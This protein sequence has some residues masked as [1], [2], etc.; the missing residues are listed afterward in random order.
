MR[1]MYAGQERTLLWRSAPGTAMHDTPLL[2][3]RL[4]GTPL[5]ERDGVAL[6]LPHLKAQALLYYLAASRASYSRDHL[7][8]LLWGDAVLNNARHSLRSA[9]YRLRQAL[10]ALGAGDA[11]LVEGD[12]LALDWRRVECDLVRFQ[13]LLASGAES[14][15]RAAVGLIRGSFLQGFSLPDAILFD[16][17]V[18]QQDAWLTRHHQRALEQL[19]AFAEQRGDWEQAMGDLQALVRLDPL[20]ERPHQRLMALYVR[21]GSPGLAQRH[22]QFVERTLHQ[23]LGIAPA[24]E[25]RA[26][27]RS[28]LVHQRTS[29]VAGAAR[30]P[31]VRARPYMLSF[32]GR[33]SSLA[34]LQQI[35]VQVAG[36]IGRAVLIEGDAGIGKSRLVDE[37]AATLS[38]AAPGDRSWQ[39]LQGR[40]SPFDTILA[41][42]AFREAFDQLLPADVDEP[43]GAEPSAGASSD[44]FARLILRTLTTLSQQG[45]ILLAIDDLHVADQLSLNLFGYLAL[46]L[47][48][49]PI[50][51][52]GTVQRLDETAALRELATLGRRRGDIEHLRLASL[53]VDAVRR[54]LSDLKVSEAA[55]ALLAPWLA[56]RSAGNPF[57]IEALIDQLRAEHLLI[58]QQGSWQ[59]DNARWMAWRAATLLPEST[60]DLVRLRLSALGPLARRVVELLAVAGGRLPVELIPV[61]MEREAP[62]TGEAIEELLERRLAVEQGET[63]ALAHELLRE[64]ALHQLSSRSRQAV[65]RRLAAAWE[66]HVPATPQT[67]EQIARHA[68]ACGDLE[69]AYRYGLALLSDLP[70]AYTGAE[71]VAF[72]QRLADLVSP[73]APLEDQYRLAQA[74]GQAHRSLGQIE[75][76]RDWHQRQLHLAQQAGSVEAEAI[77]YFELAE[78]SFI[79]N[80]YGAAIAA[81]QQ[82]LGCA[83]QAPDL[84]QPALLSRGHRLLGGALAMEGSDL[85]AAEQHL[86]AAIPVHR[87]AGDSIN[88]SAALFELGNVVAQQGAIHQAIAMYREAGAVLHADQAPFLHALAANNLAYH[89]LVLGQVDD[90]RRELQRGQT[91]AG[92]HGL[93]TALLHLFSTES[94]IHLYTGNWDGAEATSCHGLALA[95]TLGNIERQAGYRASLALVAARRGRIA[96]ARDQLEAALGMIASRTFWHL[97]T[98]LLLWLAELT[99]EHDPAAANPYLDTA[100][101]LARTQRRRLLQ[102]HAERLQALALARHDIAAAQAALLELLD[103]ASTLDLSLE[104]A[105]TRAALARV[106]LQ[107]APRSASGRAFFETALR[108][109]TG[110]GA[111]AEA[112]ALRATVS[113][114]TSSVS[115]R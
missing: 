43:D 91:I 1:A 29:T 9:L 113:S 73:A 102:L 56:G 104:I 84:Q 103:Q 105:R 93:S 27:L 36:G 24:E 5:A 41:Y 23:E 112:A 3:I 100:L 86:R 114:I 2:T 64:V 57:V 18:H 99:L 66:R 26:I 49:M 72:L 47:Q 8:A 83:A 96:D 78:M 115:H 81:A 69:R 79:R 107:H 22:F 20:D 62:A 77:A 108:E 51:L 32:A 59:L 101:A 52:I 50:M 87:Q 106:T 80:D 65:H 89:H 16:E 111:Y 71:T 7:A 74:L 90:A 85:Q 45:P 68:V 12:R 55:G 76:A 94:E 4:L 13:Q 75:Q 34:R 31:F 25:T 60:H 82:G 42:G 40:C 6:T 44:R 30:V 70:H 35:S 11:L 109:L 67:A 46:R 48:R 95:E 58:L 97:R 10:D 88:L 38:S 61:A 14:D 15:L 28:A 33:E 53:D 17:F 19:S 37:F 21:S 92:R 54:I 39:I 63:V 98:R 110:H